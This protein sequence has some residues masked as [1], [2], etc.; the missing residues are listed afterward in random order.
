MGSRDNVFTGGGGRVVL[1]SFL[2][3]NDIQGLI[4]SCSSEFPGGSVGQ[5]SGTVTAVARVAS[6]AWVQSLAREL[7]HATVTAKK[8]QKNKDPPTYI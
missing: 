4:K 2:L 7:P 1:D 8:K 3:G 6:V 5:G